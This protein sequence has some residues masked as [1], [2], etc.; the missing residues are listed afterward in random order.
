[1]KK[2]T[3]AVLGVLLALGT[4]TGCGSGRVMTFE[5]KVLEIR[6]GELLV[7]TVDG[8]QAPPYEELLVSTD[9]EALPQLR[10]GDRISVCFTGVVDEASPG[11]IDHVQSIERLDRPEIFP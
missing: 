1:M 4:M 7:E 11:R 2:V 8:P 6:D 10:M 9:V 5:A 3:A